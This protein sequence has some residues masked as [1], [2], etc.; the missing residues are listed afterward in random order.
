MIILSSS[1]FSLPF[2]LV[3]WDVGSDA[4]QPINEGAGV[5]K[6]L[7]RPV[8][9]LGVAEETGSLHEQVLEDDDSGGHLDEEVG[10]AE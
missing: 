1:F 5:N 7:K 8:V 9:E 6:H 4:E 3:E 2:L 10:S